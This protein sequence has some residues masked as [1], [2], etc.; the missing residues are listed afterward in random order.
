MILGVLV[1]LR[2]SSLG[3][4]IWGWPH[5]WYLHLRDWEGALQG[6][7]LSPFCTTTGSVS[8]NANL[9]MLIWRGFQSKNP[10]QQLSK[11]W[12]QRTSFCSHCFVGF[13]SDPSWTWQFPNDFLT[14]WIN[15][16]FTWWMEYLDA[17]VM[18]KC[19]NDSKCGPFCS[20]MVSLLQ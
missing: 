8:L 4:G 16:W 9:V 11:D 5:T 10:C 15:I 18:T 3:T 14:C 19:N 7:G 6:S 1:G 17:F 13:P 12:G 20:V 2:T